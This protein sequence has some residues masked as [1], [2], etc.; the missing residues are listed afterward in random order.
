MPIRL[1]SHLKK[2]RHGI[3]YFRVNKNG[4]EI[5][6][7]LRTRDPRRAKIAAYTLSASI[8]SVEFDPKKFRSFE[9]DIQRG[10]ARAEPGEDFQNMQKA[11]ADLRDLIQLQ[12][13]MQTLPPAQPEGQP[14]H[15]ITISAASTE[16]SKTLQN[17]KTKSAF[18]RSIELFIE[19]HGDVFVDEILPVDAVKWNAN[20][21]ARGVGQRSADNRL[22]ALQSLLKWCYKNEYIG[23]GQKLATAGKFNL[24]KGQRQ[25]ITKGANAFSVAELSI[26]FDQKKYAKWASESPARWWLP[27]VALHS[28]MRLEEAA[29]LQKNDIKEENGIVFFD[30]SGAGKQ[31]KTEAAARR[32][33]MHNDL[34]KMGFLEYVKKA[35]GGG[36]WPE[37]RRGVNGLGNPVSKSFIRHLEAVGVRKTGDRSK[38]FHSMRDTFN[39]TLEKNGVPELVRSALMGH[40]NSSTNSTSY[41][42][43]SGLERLKEEGIDK[44][45]FEE[46]IGGKLSVFSICSI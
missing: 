41:T 17:T 12:M 6:F 21:L 40:A 7:S 3:Y 2:S 36:L 27:I 31:L 26:I 24:T 4:K 29:G 35:G 10:I 45:T 23:H 1:A 18:V 8:F 32:I 19:F 30:L 42:M 28:G 25:K 33:P 16:W 20:L 44:L 37:L 34:Q 5:S 46:K 14:A 39:N 15:R 43:A 38:V 13:K 22:Q 9:L 11:T